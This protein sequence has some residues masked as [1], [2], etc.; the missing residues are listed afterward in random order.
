MTRST[1]GIVPNSTARPSISGRRWLPPRRLPRAG[2]RERRSDR[3]ATRD[4]PPDDMRL[5]AGATTWSAPP[6]CALR[7]IIDVVPEARP[8]AILHEAANPRHEH[9]WT[10]RGVTLPEGSSRA[11]RLTTNF[12]GTRAGRPA[13]RALRQA[14]RAEPDGRQ[15]PSRPR[16]LPDRSPCLRGPS[17][18]QWPKAALA[19][20]RGRCAGTPMSRRR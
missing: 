10:V 7:D 2:P 11:Y 9:E 19:S 12:I 4:I 6:R 13:A 1:G 18:T 16:E 8:A 5:S 14:G 17:S 20:N 15:R 3:H